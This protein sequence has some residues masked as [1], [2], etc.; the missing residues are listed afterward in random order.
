MRVVTRTMPRPRYIEYN[1]KWLCISV[2]RKWGGDGFARLVIELSTIHVPYNVY[3]V[4]K[5]QLGECAIITY[6]ES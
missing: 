1:P 6:K 5:L 4:L 2:K 3:S